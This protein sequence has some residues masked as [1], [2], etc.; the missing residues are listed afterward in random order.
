MNVVSVPLPW[1]CQLLCFLHQHRSY[2]SLSPKLSLFI[3]CACPSFALQCFWLL[4][5]LLLKHLSLL[6]GGRGV[7]GQTQSLFGSLMNSQSLAYTGTPRNTTEASHLYLP[8][9]VQTPS[10]IT[11]S[12][13]VWGKSQYPLKNKHGYSLARS[14][15]L[16]DT[17]DIE[18][19]VNSVSSPPFNLFLSTS[20]LVMEFTV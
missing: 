5:L 4:Q 20:N 16:D 18:I 17:S 19:Q 3:P 11:F 14:Q 10:R 8:R 6:L 1:K 12:A 13:T 15:S 9:A 2:L 7:G